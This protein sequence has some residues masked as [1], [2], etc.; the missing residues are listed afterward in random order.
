[1]I[2]YCRIHHVQGNFNI[3]L[4]SYFD[5]ILCFHQL[6]KTT[7]SGVNDVKG[8]YTI[9]TNRVSFISQYKCSHSICLDLYIRIS[10]HLL[11]K[12]DGFCSNTG[13]QK[14][15]RL[16]NLKG[17]TVIIYS[18]IQATHCYS[19]PKSALIYG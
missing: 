16:E 2:E 5:N 13:I 19:V 12:C 8:E 18:S 14:N 11:R 10:H 6:Q 4:C 7:E 17:H 15:L 1:M 9:E 3:K